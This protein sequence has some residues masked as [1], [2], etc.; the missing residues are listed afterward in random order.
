M[1]QFF[2]GLFIFRRQFEICLR[3]FR[4]SALLILVFNKTGFTRFKKG[5]VFSGF[6]ISGFR[7]SVFLT[8][9][10]YLG[11]CVCTIGNLPFFDHR[12]HMWCYQEF[13]QGPCQEGQQFILPNDNTNTDSEPICVPTDC[14]KDQVRYEDTCIPVITCSAKE[15]VMFNVK[16]HSSECIEEQLAIRQI[17][18][19]PKSCKDG[20]SLDR[21]YI[22]QSTNS[23]GNSI[24]KR[25]ALGRHKNMRAFLRNRRGT[26]GENVNSCPVQFS[27]LTSLFSSLHFFCIF[28][29]ITSIYIMEY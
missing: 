29:F 24:G 27:G 10:F 9:L 13:L 11:E 17:I 15:A 6:Q 14:P 1:S 26:V 19:V 16:K 5:F 28:F 7:I 2:W 23:R 21:R 18:S 3:K 4:M 22:C 25:F 8:T 20:E 12:G